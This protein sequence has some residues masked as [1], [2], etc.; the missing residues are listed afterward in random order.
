MQCMN[1]ELWKKTAENFIEMRTEQ[2]NLHSYYDPPEKLQQNQFRDICI[3]LSC[4]N[5]AD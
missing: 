4:S 2:F 3:E 1:F 5:Q